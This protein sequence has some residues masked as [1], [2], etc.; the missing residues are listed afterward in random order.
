MWLFSLHPAASGSVYA[1]NGGVNV[2]SA[3]VK[4]IFVDGVMLSMLDLIG[5]GIAFVGMSIIVLGWQ[6]KPSRAVF[7]Y[8]L[9]Q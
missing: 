9:K 1:I 8:C 4:F 2:T 3:L 7:F 5:A 6:A